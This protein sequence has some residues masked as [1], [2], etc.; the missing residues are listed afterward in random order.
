MDRAGTV[1][2]VLRRAAASSQR[3]IHGARRV[4]TGRRRA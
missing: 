4:L 1:A 2:H 3:R